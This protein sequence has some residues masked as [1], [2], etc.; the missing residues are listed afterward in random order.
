M[1]NNLTKLEQYLREIFR[2]FDTEKTGR[3][4]PQTLMEALSKA[5][6]IVLTQMQ[7][8]ILRNFAVKESDGNVDY[9][10][11][12]RFLAEMIKKFFCPSTLKKQV[13]IV[14]KI[15]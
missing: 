12:S 15:F 13:I 6:R 8:Y 4:S 11:Q 10:K 5:Q 14:S 7:L 9:N 1:E 2:I 3:I